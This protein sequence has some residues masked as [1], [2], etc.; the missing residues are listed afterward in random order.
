MWGGSG[1]DISFDEFNQEVPQYP[2]IGTVGGNE[3]FNGRKAG[4]VDTFVEQEIVCLRP[5]PIVWR[6]FPGAKVRRPEWIREIHTSPP[7]SLLST[8][9]GVT[10]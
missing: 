8:K 3:I 2:I 9:G 4:G 5:R 6:V 7:R 1:I 10:L